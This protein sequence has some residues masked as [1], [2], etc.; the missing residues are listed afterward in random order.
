MLAAAIPVATAMMKASLGPSVAVLDVCRAAREVIVIVVVLEM[1]VGF[2]VPCPRRS[3]PWSDVC[4][5]EEIKSFCFFFFRK[6]RRFLNFSP[7]NSHQM[8]DMKDHNEGHAARTSSPAFGQIGVLLGTIDWSTT[9]LGD[10][11]AWPQSLRTIIETMLPSQH[12]MMLA[13]GPDLTLFYNPVSLTPLTEEDVSETAPKVAAIHGTALL[14]D[15]EE[16][17]RITTADML[18][19]LGFDVVEAKSAEE[20][21]R[22]IA[23]GAKLDVVVTDHLMPGMSGAELARSLRTTR[24]DLPVLL[25]SGYADVAG[26]PSD[27]ARLSKP[28]RNADLAACLFALMPGAVR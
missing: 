7:A 6:R 8:R 10:A 4:A 3:R 25:V 14:V 18:M 9:S 16:L 17:V 21:S 11:L 1:G 20:A 2:S 15:D 23:A 12:G 22:M 24:P 26:I 13:W 5:S 19:D 27:V 28:F